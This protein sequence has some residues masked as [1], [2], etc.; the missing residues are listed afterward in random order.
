MATEVQRAPQTTDMADGPEEPMSVRLRSLQLGEA[1][2]RRDGGSWRRRITWLIALA[3]IAG[4]AGLAAKYR[5]TGGAGELKEFE[6][7]S[8]GAPK[9]AESLQLAGF[10]YPRH[11]VKI[12]PRSAGTIIEFPVSVGD[13][14][15]KGQLI[16]QVD[17][18]TYQAQVDQAKASLEMAQI[19]LR[20]L[21]NGALPEEIAAA[22]ALRD[23]AKATAEFLKSELERRI[24]LNKRNNDAVT[25]AEMV[26]T[27]SKYT[28]AQATLRNQEQQVALI[29][30][31]PREERIAAA[32]AEVRRNEAALAN[33]Q[34]WRLV[35]R[36][37]SPIDGV[38]LRKTAEAGEDIHPELA[39]TSLCEVA[40][41]NDLLAQ[42]DVQE[43]SLKDVQIGQKCVIVPDAYKDQKYEAHVSFIEP[44]LNVA[45]GVGTVHVKIDNPDDRLMVNMNCQV[46]FE[47]D[48]TK[49]AAAENSVPTVPQSALLKDGD[50]SY[51]YVVEN[52]IAHKRVVELGATVDSDVEIKSGLTKGD[53]V[54]QAPASD[55]QDGQSVKIR[56]QASA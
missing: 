43:D 53:I 21:Q 12:T 2:R 48:A 16:A 24:E 52:Q 22:E 39:F 33:S 15:T 9:P 28:E 42:V 51:V 10:V 4:G 19:Q 46:T 36:L 41:M 35:T 55:L 54:I 56:T 40:D 30:R 13:K 31:G 44:V 14:V 5:G 29:K 17:P 6:A 23:Q 26:Q 18:T 45:R 20:E 38:V 25:D 37:E 1:E 47:P 50:Q 49:A 7:F 34:Y 27:V 8:F 3:A 32:E 11:V